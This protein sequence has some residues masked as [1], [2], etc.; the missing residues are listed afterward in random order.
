MCWQ[1]SRTGCWRLLQ[2]V[3][4]RRI[5]APFSV[6]GRHACSS[7]WLRVWGVRCRVQGFSSW[8]V[9]GLRLSWMSS[10]GVG[11]TLDGHS[12]NPHTST[13]NPKPQ[14]PNPES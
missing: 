10:T 11:Q 5:P 9:E 1:I 13:F 12:R 6:H 14:T 7:V 3:P 8:R 4:F 2:G